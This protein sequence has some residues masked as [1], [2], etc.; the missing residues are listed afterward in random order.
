MKILQY[1]VASLLVCA[2]C[3]LT[4]G[5][6]AYI[7]GGVASAGSYYYLD[8][9]AR[10]TYNTSLDAAYNAS[11]SAC[12]EMGITVT[13]QVMKVASAKVIGKLS[14]DMVTISLKLIGDNITEIIVRVGIWGNEESSRRI[15][16]EISSRL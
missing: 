10:A 2:M 5:C 4:V 14:N 16:K 7:A 11:V 13:D 12:G 1:S 9:Q 6:G 8:G 3:F 15:Q